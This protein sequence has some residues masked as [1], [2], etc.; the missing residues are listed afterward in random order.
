MT[1][2][3]MS[4]AVIQAEVARLVH[5]IKA[6]KEDRQTIAIPMPA[7]LAVLDSGGCNWYM[8]YGSIAGIY[9]H[10]VRDMVQEVKDRWNLES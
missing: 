5:Q 7:P 3:K 9:G 1:T 10:A 2:P 6:V 4:A 8:A